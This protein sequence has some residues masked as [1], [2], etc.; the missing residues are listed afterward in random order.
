MFL[1]RAKG[2]ALLLLAV[3]VAGFSGSPYRRLKTKIFEGAGLV[4]LPDLA[5]LMAAQ[6]RADDPP[7]VPAYLKQFSFPDTTR[8]RKNRLTYRD[9]TGNKAVSNL[10]SKHKRRR[11]RRR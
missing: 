1:R 11:R 6:A 5:E 4:R 9:P 10:E 7:Q 3:G 2:L 8:F